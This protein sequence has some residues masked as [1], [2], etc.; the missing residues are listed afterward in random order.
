MVPWRRTG[1]MHGERDRAMPRTEGWMEIQTLTRQGGSQRAIARE[2]SHHAN[3]VVGRSASAGW[4]RAVAR[5]PHARCSRLQ[6]KTGRS[7]S[8]PR[9]PTS[10][11]TRRGSISDRSPRSRGDR[12]GR[13][14]SAPAWMAPCSSWMSNCHQAVPNRSAGLAL[15]TSPPARTTTPTAAPR[16]RRCPAPSATPAS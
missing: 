7:G 1:A 2:N 8:G 5:H 6:V 4:R 11:C 15:A 12:R 13:H 10:Y 3:Q 16:G 9:P 14:S